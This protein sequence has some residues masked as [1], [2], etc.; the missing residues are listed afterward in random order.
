MLYFSQKHRAVLQEA[1]LC[2][3]PQET[4][5]ERCHSAGKQDIN[6]F[7]RKAAELGWGKQTPGRW[8]KVSSSPLAS[9]D[10]S[11]SKEWRARDEAAVGPPP[12]IGLPSLD[13]FH[14]GF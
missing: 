10:T 6:V 4:W 13:I 5:P 2:S 12:A 3:I 14:I 8:R 7:V 1:A 9:F 11:P